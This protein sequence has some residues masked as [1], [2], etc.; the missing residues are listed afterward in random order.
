MSRATNH[1]GFFADPWRRRNR[2]PTTVQLTLTDIRVARGLAAKVA[3]HPSMSR[4]NPDGFQARAD[5][6]VVG[7]LGEL[8]FVRLLSKWNREYT[9]IRE[10]SGSDNGDVE[11]SLQGGRVGWMV[12]VKTAGE[13][14]HRNMLVPKRAL[15]RGRLMDAYVG[16]RLNMQRA[17]VELWGW[18]T[19]EELK[20]RP[21]S[22]GFNRARA[23]SV[24]TP[25][26]ELRPIHSLIELIDPKRQT[27]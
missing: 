27:A 25:L 17:Q 9:C 4:P 19:G 15:T 3:T 8:A 21:A 11:I 22:P 13:P 23:F 16:A 6:Y 20:R 12:D 2:A 1:A 26:S 24:Y 7:Y 14:T 5:R 18:L 10:T